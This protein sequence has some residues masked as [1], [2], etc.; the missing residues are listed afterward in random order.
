MAREHNFPIHVS[1]EGDRRTTATVAGKQPLD[2]AVPPEFGG[3]DPDLWSPEDAFV[4]AA[5]SC[6]VV[7]IAALAGRD[8]VAL[9]DVDVE[10][11]GVVGRRADGNYGFV[12][13]E[14]SVQIETD[15]G[16]EDAVRALVAEAEQGC[17]V[18]VSLALPIEASVQVGTRPAASAGAA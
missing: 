6:L 10:T 12:R 3:T 13:I 9:H 5:G 8:G 2:I 7:T 16:C 17:L 14:H 1:W 18:S 11:R 15:V 4:A